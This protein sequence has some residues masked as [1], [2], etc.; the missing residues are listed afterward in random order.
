MESE[1]AAMQEAA[2]RAYADEAA[3]LRVWAGATAAGA[4]HAETVAVLAAKTCVDNPVWAANAVVKARRAA[5]AIGAA[6]AARATLELMGEIPPEVRETYGVWTKADADAMCDEIAAAEAESVQC[7][8]WFRRDVAN[9]RKAFA[10]AGKLPMRDSEGDDSAEYEAF[11]S[12][13]RRNADARSRYLQCVNGVV[14]E[15]E[16]GSSQSSS[17]AG[18]CDGS[19]GCGCDKRGE[20]EA[21]FFID[22]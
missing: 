6:A 12:A 2:D 11:L 18:W 19:E 1:L 16:S 15:S 4:A 17:V 3:A 14:A 9:A 5:L 8:Q 13:R 22:A 20:E 10:S 7:T 21:Q